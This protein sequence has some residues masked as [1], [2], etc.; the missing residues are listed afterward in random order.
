MID[1]DSIYHEFEKVL[2][3]KAV[4]IYHPHDIAKTENCLTFVIPSRNIDEVALLNYKKATKTRIMLALNT[5]NQPYACLNV[6]DNVIFCRP[7]EVDLVINSFEMFFISNRWLN[8]D[9]HDLLSLFS[10]G[11]AIKF[12]PIICSNS[13]VFEQRLTSILLNIPNEIKALYFCLVVDSD[14]S[15]DTQVMFYE[16]LRR[17]ISCDIDEISE[18]VIQILEKDESTI[19]EKLENNYWIGLY[20]VMDKSPLDRN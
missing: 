7:H 2:P 15:L 1:S 9:Y 17:T 14:F 20:F 16:V 11:K 4:H 13:Q 18:V 12:I 10:K 8:V 5:D 6:V 3:K 19:W